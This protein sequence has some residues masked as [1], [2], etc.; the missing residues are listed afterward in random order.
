MCPRSGDRQDIDS[1]EVRCDHCI[2]SYMGLKLWLNNLR[3]KRFLQLPF[4]QGRHHFEGKRTVL[5][6]SFQKLVCAF[7]H[8]YCSGWRC[9]G[10]QYP[11]NVTGFHCIHIV[12]LWPSQEQ[13]S[14]FQSTTTIERNRQGTCLALAFPAKDD[15][16][17]AM[18]QSRSVTRL[19]IPS[20]V[21]WR[22][23]TC[24]RR[25]AEDEYNKYVF[26]SPWL[27]IYWKERWCNHLSWCIPLP[28]GPVTCPHEHWQK[29]LFY[30]LIV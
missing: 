2:G 22:W 9:A 30:L 21:V 26:L 12:V 25:F 14:L 3:M 10:V 4:I 1:Q 16:H 20:V 24:R 23:K 13:K 27:E 11:K 8:I 6:Y 29:P 17:S 5:L 19:R 28:C 7:A 15:F 18:L